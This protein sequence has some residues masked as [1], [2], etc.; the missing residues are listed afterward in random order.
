ML[1]VIDALTKFTKLYAVNT[2]T[3]E[4][5]CALRTYFIEYSRPKRIIN[6]R[7][8]GLKSKEFEEFCRENDITHIKNAVASPQSNGQKKELIVL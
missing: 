1:A 5:V 7:G 4:T 8:T 3:K 6:D 2:G